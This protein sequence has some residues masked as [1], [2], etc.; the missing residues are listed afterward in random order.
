MRT[1]ERRTKE[2]TW[3]RKF[4]VGKWEWGRKWEEGWRRERGKKSEG[5]EWAWVWDEGSMRTTVGESL[6][7][8]GW[9]REVE[10]KNTEQPLGF[11]W[12]KVAAR[13]LEWEPGMWG[14][15]TGHRRRAGS[16]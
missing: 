4:E 9:S 15:V 5:R 6:Q 8:E 10:K 2:A 11:V 1:E 7:K 14:R 16:A 12:G 13:V 3:A